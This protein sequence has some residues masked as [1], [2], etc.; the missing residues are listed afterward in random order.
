MPRV[1]FAAGQLAGG[2]GEAFDGGVGI[3]SEEDG[4]GV[5]EALGD[6]GG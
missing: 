3:G 2:F 1:L 5:A 4:G 6:V